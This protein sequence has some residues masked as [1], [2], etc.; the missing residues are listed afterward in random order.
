MKKL[1]LNRPAMAALMAGMAAVSTA[2][3]AWTFGSGA[4]VAADA[5]GVSITGITGA[6]AANGGTLST[7]AAGTSIVA[8]GTAGCTTACGN[9]YNS[10]TNT[11]STSNTYGIGGFAAAGTAWTVNSSSGLTL[12]SGGLGMSSDSSSSNVPNH[13]LD[14]GPATNISNVI[15]GVGNTESVLLSFSSST[16]L[17]SVGIGWKSGDADISVFRYIGSATVAPALNGTGAGLGSMQAAGWEL[18]GNYGDLSVD[19]SSPYSCVNGTS[20]ASCT[21]GSGK[22]SSWWLISA[23]NTSYGAAT[24]GTVDQGNDFFKLYAAAG[25]KCTSTVAG[26]CGPGGGGGGGSVPE[27][28]S[29]ALA[30]LALFGVVA[31]RRRVTKTACTS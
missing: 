15:S 4:T 21:G 5:T 14:N 22:G 2:N 10:V 20:T 12:Y 30:G 17:T 27:P 7:G 6:Y 3:A 24:T 31:T 13:A 19:T 18:V 9:T 8:A 29:L 11:W 28:G 16:V 25:T 1:G 23:Y 26:V